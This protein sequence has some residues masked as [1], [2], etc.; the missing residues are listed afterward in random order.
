MEVK[1]MARPEIT[2]Q[3]IRDVLLYCGI[4]SANKEYR[5]VITAESNLG[6]HVY[7][8]HGPASQLSHGARKTTSPVYLVTAT[9]LADEIIHKKISKKHY[10]LVRDVRNS[11]PQV[12]NSGSGSQ[13][14]RPVRSVKPQSKLATLTAL[15]EEAR[16]GIP[17]LI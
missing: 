1:D 11:A 9:R 4:G 10:Q 6:Y 7:T 15:N 17:I 3:I 16:R 8:E 5:V 13:T 12:I 14:K 2:G